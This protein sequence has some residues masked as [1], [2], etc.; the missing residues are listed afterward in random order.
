[1]W[2]TA[3][4]GTVQGISVGDLDGDGVLEVATVVRTTTD[5]RIVVHDAA[6][7]LRW[8][9]VSA[10]PIAGFPTFADFDGDGAD[11]IGYCELS[12]TGRCIV[13][14]GNGTQLWA[15]GPYYYPGM[16]MGGP[17]AASIN[18]N[19]GVDM[20]VM[21]WGGYV[22]LLDGATGTQDWYYD[23]WTVHNELF[24]GHAAIGDLDNNGTLEIVVGGA[25]HG[26]V[27]ALDAATGAEVWFNNDLA[28]IAGTFKGSGVALADLDGAQGTLEVIFAVEATV[29]RLMAL[30]SNGLVRWTTDVDEILTW[31]TPVV[32]DIDGDGLPEAILQ[33]GDGTIRV[34]S[35][36]GVQRSI[37]EL[38][39]TSW[40]S[41]V[42]L[43]DVNGDYKP[44]IIAATRHKVFVL[45]SNLTV[46][47][48]LD[49]AGSGLN[50]SACVADLDGAGPGT[51]MILLGGYTSQK[52]HALSLG[53]AINYQWTTLAGSSRHTAFLA[54][55][56]PPPV[57]A[58]GETSST[59]TSADQGDMVLG[60]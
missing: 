26:T 44:E 54:T 6:G 21:S 34:Y 42:A 58:S 2:A 57:G 19:P 36:A 60:Y 38:G 18:A 11:E 35:N 32:A 55:T 17:A 25:Y 16:S 39:D 41:G 15:S 31:R 22:A 13:L 12:T 9:V 28:E 8:S 50:A 29:P 47:A 33:S 48:Q 1:S 59:S 27:I 30:E 4:N 23:A 52:V 45:D 56:A 49:V 7:T 46:L 20:V 37:T 40:M 24:H 43:A 3:V 53:T 10:T 14:D 51:G 5:Q